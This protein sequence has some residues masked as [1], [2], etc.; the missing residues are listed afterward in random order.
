M[1]RV[2]ELT[3]GDVLIHWDLAEFA[4]TLVLQF[5]AA[6][7]FFSRVIGI[8]IESG[9]GFLQFSAGAE[10]ERFSGEETDGDATALIAF[11]RSDGRRVVHDDAHRIMISKLFAFQVVK[12]LFCSVDVH[13]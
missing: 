3:V 5:R 2:H 8:S 13:A 7:I 11:R 10:F 1:S 12:D 9:N 4:Q 6:E